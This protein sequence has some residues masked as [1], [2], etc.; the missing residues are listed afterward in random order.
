M[1]EE[2]EDSFDDD[3]GAEDVEDEAVEE[4][5]EEDFDYE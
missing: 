4:G 3:F 1:G 5:E 2:G